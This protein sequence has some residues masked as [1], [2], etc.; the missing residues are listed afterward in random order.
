MTTL[1]AIGGNHDSSGTIMEQF[2]R[3]SGGLEASI[4]ILATASGLKN[5]GKEQAIGL[6]KF[7]KSQI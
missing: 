5:S 1:L 7:S 4:V 6:A 3:L 2:L